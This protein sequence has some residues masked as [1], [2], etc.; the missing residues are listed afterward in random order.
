M[1]NNYTPTYMQIYL[2]H[3]IVQSTCINLFILNLLIFLVIQSRDMFYVL[4]KCICQIEGWG[5]SGYTPGMKQVTL[6]DVLNYLFKLSIH[7]ETQEM[8]PRAYTYM[9]SSHSNP[10]YMLESNAPYC[11]HH[12]FRK[13]S[14]HI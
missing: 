5:E 11:V 6:Q 1:C 10:V 2:V 9:K 3:V 7:A 12:N 8:K 13:S 14:L 4:V